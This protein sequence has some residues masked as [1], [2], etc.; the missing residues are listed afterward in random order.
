MYNT[1]T[2]K[3]STGKD[4]KLKLFDESDGEEVDANINI[5][6]QFFGGKG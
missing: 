5:K 4:D 1:D 2:S 3:P 6:P